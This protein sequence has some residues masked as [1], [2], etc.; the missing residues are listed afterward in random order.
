NGFVMMREALVDSR[1]VPT[2]R[3]A[4]DVGLA[5]VE[6]LAREAGIRSDVPDVPSAAIGSG[7]VT[8]LELTASYTVFANLGTAVR[9]RLVQRVVDEGGTVVWQSEPD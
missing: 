1:N 2:V 3:L 9:P 4:Q 7:A 8:P 6:R 5:N